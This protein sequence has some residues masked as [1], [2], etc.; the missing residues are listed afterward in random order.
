[1]AACDE[2]EEVLLEVGAG[3][4]NGVDFVLPNHFCERNANFGGAHCPGERNHHFPAS[5]E[6]RG[7]GLGCIFEDCRVE[8]TE[9]PINKLADAPHLYFINSSSLCF[10]DLMQDL[11]RDNQALITLFLSE[12]FMTPQQEFVPP[13]CLALAREGELLLRAQSP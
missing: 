8:V 12:T 1:M 10:L 6:M 13:E 3:A 9:M 5:L 2:V 7:I 4:G 11:Y